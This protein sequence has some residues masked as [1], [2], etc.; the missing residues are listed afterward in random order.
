LGPLAHCALYIL[1]HVVERNDEVAQ[2]QR[3]AALRSLHLNG[4][5][6]QLEKA[7]ITLGDGTLVEHL[8][9]DTYEPHVDPRL[10]GFLTGYFID[11]EGKV[12]AEDV[13]AGGRRGVLASTDGLAELH[14]DLLDVADSH[15]CVDSSYVHHASLL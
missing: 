2:R 1:G 12:P 10:R 7:D 13:D 3:H 11:L 8:A 15:G 9:G 4:K 6:R 5:R 14:R